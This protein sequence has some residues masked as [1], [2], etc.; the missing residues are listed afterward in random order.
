[1]FHSTAS[2]ALYLLVN[3]NM[4]NSLIKISNLLALKTNFHFIK[5]LVLRSNEIFERSK[6][7]SSKRIKNQ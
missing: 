4:K 1:M 3:S 6:R 2:R 5:R 7:I